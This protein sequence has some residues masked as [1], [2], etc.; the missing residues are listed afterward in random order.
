MAS[1]EVT[2]GISDELKSALEKTQKDLADA[3]E[4]LSEDRIRRIVREELEAHEKRQ[5]Q[6][7][8]FGLPIRAE[9]K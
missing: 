3:K 5:Q 4:A 1:A 2:V 9:T 6:A 7:R 8:R